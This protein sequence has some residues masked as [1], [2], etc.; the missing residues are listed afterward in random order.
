MKSLVMS[1]IILAW[2]KGYVVNKQ[3]S[4]E[5]KEMNVM[6]TSSNTIFVSSGGVKNT[7]NVLGQPTRPVLVYMGEVPP[8]GPP[9][10]VQA[11]ALSPTEIRISWLPPL[12]DQQNGEL[13]GYK[14]FYQSGTLARNNNVVPASYNSHT[15]IFLDMYTNYTISILAFNPAGDGP[16]SEVISVR[17][18][19]GTPGPPSNLS[20]S[21]I[22]ANSLKLSWNKPLQPNGE[23]V[24]Y[25]VAYEKAKQDERENLSLG[26]PSLQSETLFHHG[27]DMAVDG[28]TK[29]CSF[30]TAS[31]DQRWWMTQIKKTVVHSV[32]VAIT[33]GSQQN[34]TIFVV[35]L[36]EGS[37]TVY[38]PCSSFKETY[39]QHVAFFLCNGGEGHE[40]EFVYISD[41]RKE[42]EYFSLCEVRVFST[43]DY[44]VQVK[45]WVSENFMYIHD[46]EE[47]TLY[48]FSV[49][50][51]T[52]ND[53]GPAVVGNVT[54]SLSSMGDQ[55]T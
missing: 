39:D 34:F 8:K 10:K 19:P 43:S 14:I 42:E 46:L 50:A 31:T 51:H 27:A 9:R 11:E 24:G 26:Q 13:L 16:E 7:S 55:E 23:I 22:T 15:L 54:T 12:A 3:I 29:T 53:F 1:A 45:H 4:A 36:L 17:T 2:V 40:G 37:K 33:P 52:I 35:Q 25:K 49:V 6:S 28:D 18:L 48:F 32:E 30:T 21:E 47:R 20:F 5:P 41:D 44:S 38:K